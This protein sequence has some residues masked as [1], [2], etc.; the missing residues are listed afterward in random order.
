VLDLGC[1]Q[2]FFS[3]SLSQLGARVHG[4]DF[5]E[6]NIAVCKA[7][8]E[9]RGDRGILFET[10]R[11]EDVLS[12]LEVNR[13]DL[14]LGLS[15]FH[16]IVQARGAPPARGMLA[17]AGVKVAAALFEI[18]VAE[19]PIYWTAAQPQSARELLSDYAFVHETRHG[20][21]LSDVRRPFY[22]TSNRCWYLDGQA[23]VFDR[24]TAVSN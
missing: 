20:T 6:A 3:H 18:A 2:G 12:R 11:I 1:A 14:I 7:L 23:A 19:E 21:H 9:E 22:F 15:V 10:A 17:A 4:V 16:H 5:L 24:W 8:A 13:Y